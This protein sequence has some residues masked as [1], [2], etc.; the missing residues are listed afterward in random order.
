MAKRMTRP[1][2]PGKTD[3]PSGGD[4]DGV[5]DRAGDPVARFGALCKSRGLPL[6]VQR[7]VVLEALLARHDHPTADA[8]LEDVRGRLPGVSRTTVYR[9]LETLVRVGA[10]A[11]ACHLGP[12]VRYDPNLEPHHHLV[13]TAC[14]AVTDVTAPELDA[15]SAPPAAVRR[16]GFRVAAS[17]VVFRGLCRGCRDNRRADPDAPPVRLAGRPRHSHDHDDP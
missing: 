1:S 3:C 13:C 4:G 7:R 2:K 17:T 10:A 11:K 8:L 15:L 12:A 6:T 16:A 9:V 14:D 5:S